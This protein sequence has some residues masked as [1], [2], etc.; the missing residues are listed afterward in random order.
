MLSI[1]DFKVI[2]SQVLHINPHLILLDIHLPYEDGH[3]LCRAIRKQ[4]QVPIIIVTSKNTEMDELMSINLGADDFVTK[5]YNM[6]ILLARIES[7]L[8]RSYDTTN[9]TH[10]T[11]N[12]LTLDLSKGI[13]TYHNHDTELTK[14]E[15]KMLAQIGRAHV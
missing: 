5:P 2:T 6:Q 14:N 13:V 7:V 12:G 8:K 9:D 11:Y 4:S 3:T 15:F 10:L 1:T